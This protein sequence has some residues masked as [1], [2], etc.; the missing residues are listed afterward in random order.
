MTAAV[1]YTYDIPTLK[2][3]LKLALYLNKESMVLPLISNL[4]PEAY[5]DKEI[6]ELVGLIY[7]RKHKFKSAVNFIEDLQ[8]PNAENIKGNIYLEKKQYEL[9]YGQFKLALAKKQNSY[10]AIERAIS[11]AWILNQWQ[12]GLD[13]SQKIILND[14]NEASRLTL[15]AAFFTNLKGFDEASKRLERAQGF[16][17]NKPPK[18]LSQLYSYVSLMREDHFTMKKYLNLACEAADGFSCW[19]ILNNQ[20]WENFAKTI[21]RDDAISLGS[22]MTLASL[23]SKADLDPLKDPRKIDQRDIEEMDEGTAALIDQKKIGL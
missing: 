6:R 14:R 22:E 15:Q 16:F 10:N 1:T 11:L 20:V 2:I 8:T 4:N 9:A 7:Y 17:A 5:E 23:K 18:E 21:Q 3:W 13:L 19:M 12:D